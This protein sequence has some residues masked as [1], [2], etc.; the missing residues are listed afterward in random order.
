[1]TVRSTQLAA[2]H[3]TAAFTGTVFTC[4]DGWR[5][6]VKDISALNTTT[7]LTLVQAYSYHPANGAY[8]L[9]IN[10]QLAG[11]TSGFWSGWV[12]L[13]PGDLVQVAVQEAGVNVWISGTL[14]QLTGAEPMS[15]NA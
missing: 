7:G 6:I 12:V 1:M 11:N 9:L 3:S 14:L 13:N 10:E 2:Y 15:A 8:V 4:P 5:T